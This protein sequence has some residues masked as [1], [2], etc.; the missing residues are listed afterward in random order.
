MPKHSN[1]LTGKIMKVQI[2]VKDLQELL[3]MGRVAIT[4]MN[5]GHSHGWYCSEWPKIVSRLYT[6]PITDDGKSLYD[7]DKAYTQSVAD[8]CAEHGCD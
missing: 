1:Q 8:H 2:E 5:E 7:C 6:M 4:A 3:L